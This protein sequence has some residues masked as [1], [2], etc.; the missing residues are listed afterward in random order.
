MT[1][2]GWISFWATGQGLVNPDGVDG[3]TIGDPK[4]CLLPVKVSFAGVEQTPLWT[5]LIYTGEI[6]VNTMVPANIPAG[7]VE[8]VLTIGGVSSRKGVTLAVR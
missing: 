5:G 8:V 7:D 2:G 1:R 4:R 6:Q 3:E